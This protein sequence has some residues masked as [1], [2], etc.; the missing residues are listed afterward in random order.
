MSS[1]TL[2]AGNLAKIGRS[3]LAQI[4]VPTATATHKPVPHHEI[5]EA[6]IETLG[7]RHIGV[8]GE[9]YAVSSDGMKMFGVIDLQSQMEGCRFAIGLRNSHDKSFR[10]ALTVGY[11]V[12][13]CSNMAFS[14][15]FSPVLAKHSKS[16][17]LIDTL[18]V[19]MDRIQR[20]FE[21]LQRQLE[22]WRQTQITDD[23]AKLILYQA[24]VEGELEA[25]RSLLPEV[26]R[27]Y[28]NPQYQEFAA[29]TLWSLSNAFTSAFKTLDPIPQFKA[30]AKLGSFLAQLPS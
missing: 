29:R 5:V 24:F 11:R 17:N 21:P 30:T 12:F 13:V 10:L 23:R 1:S 28:F 26:H 3:T 9:E 14:G 19:G 20:N 25:P 16:F 27:L 8:V 18:A 7:F 22:T 15:D 6:L 2:I 4:P